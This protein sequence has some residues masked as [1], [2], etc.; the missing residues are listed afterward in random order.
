MPARTSI[1]MEDGE[2]VQLEKPDFIRDVAGFKTALCSHSLYVASAA[3]GL[4][5]DDT[6]TLAAGL[7]ELADFTRLAL[8]FNAP[9]AYVGGA[10][11]QDVVDRKRLTP[12]WWAKHLHS[13][14][15]G[16]AEVRKVCDAFLAL[17]E[18]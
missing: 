6:R 13:P 18:G 15:G 10:P 11:V 12:N 16:I 1:E 8:T 4:H 7:T 14:R 3:P 17:L 2:V 9:M 5:F